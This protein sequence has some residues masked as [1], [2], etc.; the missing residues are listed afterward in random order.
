MG[1]LKVGVRKFR[2]KL[3]TYLLETDDAVAI[4]RRGDTVGYYIPTGSVEKA[5][6]RLH[7]I[8]VSE[9]LLDDEDLTVFNGRDEDDD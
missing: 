5:A 6:L 8:L 4:T 2:Q 3:A 1:T 7:E 9:G